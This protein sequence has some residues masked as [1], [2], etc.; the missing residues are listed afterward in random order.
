MMPCI[1][2]NCLFVFS[3]KSNLGFLAKQ[4]PNFSLSEFQ[5]IRAGLSFSHYF[6]P[7]PIRGFAFGGSSHLGCRLSSL[8]L[9][10]L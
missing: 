1:Y 9:G 4:V 3:G 6:G 5:P 2:V 10:A 7:G 8:Y